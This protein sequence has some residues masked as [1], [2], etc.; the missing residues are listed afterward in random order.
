M[1][2]QEWPFVEFSVPESDVRSVTDSIRECPPARPGYPGW[3]GSRCYAFKSDDGR[4]TV[5]VYFEKYG[6]PCIQHLSAG[7]TWPLGYRAISLPSVEPSFPS[8][9]RHPGSLQVAR[10]DCPTCG[11]SGIPRLRPASEDAA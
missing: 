6:C 5:R 11:G 10:I 8:H 4:F 7:C 3:I 9:V 1:N 2:D